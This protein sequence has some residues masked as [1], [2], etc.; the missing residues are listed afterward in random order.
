MGRLYM[1]NRFFILELPFV[2][3]YHHQHK[4]KMKQPPFKMQAEQSE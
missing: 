4:W 2:P 1:G 3:I